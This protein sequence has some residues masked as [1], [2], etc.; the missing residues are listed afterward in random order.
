MVGM[1]REYAALM[2]TQTE[3][4]YLEKKIK[5]EDYEK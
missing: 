1:K 4:P 2:L 3:M 5:E